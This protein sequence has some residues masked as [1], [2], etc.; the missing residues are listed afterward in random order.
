MA[1]CEFCHP[2][3]ISADWSDTRTTSTSARCMASLTIC[4]PENQLWPNAIPAHLILEGCEFVQG[5][6]CIVVRFFYG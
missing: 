2:T 6:R 1:Q 3:P 5:H 4:S